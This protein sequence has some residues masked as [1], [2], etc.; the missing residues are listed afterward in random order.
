MIDRLEESTDDTDLKSFQPQISQIE[1]A[2]LNLRNLRI[3]IS[4]L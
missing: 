1:N 4:M 2:I 3:I